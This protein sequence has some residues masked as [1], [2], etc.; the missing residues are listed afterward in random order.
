MPMAEPP[1]RL[2]AKARR[3]LASIDRF[4]AAAKE[5]E[6]ARDALARE[7]ERREKLRLVHPGETDHAG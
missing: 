4:L 1:E 5:V 2:R 3:L 7:A 6:R